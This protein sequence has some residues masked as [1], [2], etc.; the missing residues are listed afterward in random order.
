M[1]MFKLEV[2]QGEQKGATFVLQEGEN[3]LGRSHKA[4][5]R[6]DAPDVS[7]LQAKITVQGGKITIA[8]LS[9]HG[10]WVNERKLMEAETATLEVGQRVR[11]GKGLVF[12]LAQQSQASE[13]TE[14]GGGSPGPS[15]AS[16]VSVTRATSPHGKTVHPKASPVTSLPLP[17]EVT[18]VSAPMS[19]VSAEFDRKMRVKAEA[20]KFDES[21][22]DF[23]NDATR[24]QQTVFLPKQELNRRLVEERTKPRQRLALILGAVVVGIVLLLVL[25]P[26]QVPEGKLQW[27]ETYVEANEPAP[28]GGYKLAY[29][30]NETT[31]LETAADGLTILTRLGRKRDV[32]LLI[33]L[34]EYVDDKWAAQESARTVEDW[35]KSGS[36]RLYGRLSY[37][38]EG[39]QNGIRIWTAS[40]TREDKGA[41]AGRISVFCHG[42]GLE[43]LSIEIPAADQARAE[44]F[45]DEY[46]YFNFPP[47]FEAA[48]WE[49]QPL[50]ANLSANALFKQIRTDLGREAPLT[51]AAIGNQLRTILSWAAL[52][53]R[54]SEEQEAQRLLVNLREQQAR[55]YNSQQLQVNNAMHSKDEKQVVVV[56]QR[57]QAVF[58]D[59]ADRRYFEVRKW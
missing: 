44:N 57:C 32:P 25:K 39:E 17:D 1:N 7:S 50:R 40:Y 51:W 23:E 46:S 24:A 3:F 31:K 20:E 38:F 41:R 2:E 56:A 37:R 53:K 34:H 29:P 43:V 12:R 59:E 5:I 14:I 36:D 55:W 49:G 27:D 15:S 11:A 13:D 10:T 6:L 54:T 18:S 35:M 16:T 45:L 42:R 28:R 22:S 4:H 47:E 26:K 48:H 19:V 33:S 8:N 58:S 30:K 21:T 52:E 9:Q